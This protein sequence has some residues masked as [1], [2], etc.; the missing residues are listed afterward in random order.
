MRIIIDVPPTIARRA[1]QAVEDGLFRSIDALVVEALFR[2][3][4]TDAG[5]PRLPVRGDQ[6]L[7]RALDEPAAS[8]LAASLPMGEYVYSTASDTGWLWGMINRVF[9][10]K[11]AVRT[12]AEMAR[13]G[14]VLLQSLHASFADRGQRVGELLAAADREQG[15][16]RNEALAVGFP[17]SSDEQKARVRFAHQFI[18]RRSAAGTYVGG[19][20]ETALIGVTEP[21]T[22]WVA[23]TELGWQF[24][25]LPNHVL[26][27]GATS[28]P[29]LNEPEQQFYLC[30]I[31]PQVPAE[32]N[33]FS[34]I[35]GVLSREPL[36]AS[37]LASRLRT[38]QDP[39]L[40]KTIRDTTRSGALARLTDV[41]GVFRTATGRS[42]R[43]EIA[44]LGRRAF[45]RLSHGAKI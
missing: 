12:C 1:A 10:L 24:A 19:A 13:R 28:G 2:L 38:F 26:D 21:G 17:M 3:L 33:A 40:P 18:G 41:G 23:P 20:F 43:Y 32:R 7:P 44:P 42:A 16:R 14:P 35:L 5:S 29:N 30:R 37:L 39:D 34:A 22:D 9:P 8:M 11:V 15:R 6:Q 27:Q 45:E 36:E 25:D 4:P 31:S